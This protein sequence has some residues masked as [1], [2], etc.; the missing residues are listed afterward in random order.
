VSSSGM[1]LVCPQCS[2]FRFRHQF[3]FFAKYPGQTDTVLSY[4]WLA[5]VNGLGDLGFCIF[6]K[7]RIKCLCSCIAPDCSTMT[8]EGTA[9][10][11]GAVTY[12]TNTGG[13]NSNPKPTANSTSGVLWGSPGTPGSMQFARPASV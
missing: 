8:G 13:E 6:V 11:G 4:A 1:P 7:A 9:L 2:F 12:A 5:G 10:Y 3:R